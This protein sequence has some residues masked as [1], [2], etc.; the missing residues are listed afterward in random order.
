MPNSRISESELKI[1]QILWDKGPLSSA[2]IV[3]LLDDTGWN[4][5]TIHTFLR[6]L[7]G[8][9]IVNAVKKGSFYEY[10]PL[11]SK[12]M[13]EADETRNF[14]GRVFDGS[15]SNLVS[16]FVKQGNLSSQE[17]DKLQQMLD[18]SKKEAL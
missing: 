11:I 8:K 5:K 12:E 1:M 18:Q 6:R 3:E 10:V 15:L 7:V 4:P 2:M 17:L 13:Y 14:L 9:K 16:S